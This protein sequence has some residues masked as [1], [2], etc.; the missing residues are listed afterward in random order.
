MN[1]YAFAAMGDFWELNHKISVDVKNKLLIVSPYVSTLD[2]KTE[3]YSDYKEWFKIRNNAGTGEIAI[4]TTGGDPI[5]GNQYTGDAYFLINGYRAVIDFRTTTVTGMLFS[6]DYSTPW[7][8]RDDLQPISPAFVSNLAL[9]VEPDLSNA[10]IPT[11][12]E[13]ADAVWN[14]LLG[15][16]ISGSYGERIQ[17]LLTLAQYLGLK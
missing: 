11:D 14:K 16:P 1:T 12:S 8:N 15:T 9:A 2:I 6:D 4:R 17:K 10:G 13:N 3:V 5:P 7:L